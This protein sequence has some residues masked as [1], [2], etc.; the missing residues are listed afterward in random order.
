MPTVLTHAAV[1]L[2]IGLALGPQVVSRRLLIAGVVACMLPDLDVL[3]FRL[4]VAY[5][6]AAGH[7]G[8][9]HSLV[10]SLLL[11]MIAAALAR[12]LRTSRRT[13]FLFVFASAASHG[14]LDMVTNGG[15]GV[16]L[17]WPLS[18]ERFFFPWQVI[19]ASPL[20]LRRVFSARG[21]AVFGSEILWVWLPTMAV[22]SVAVLARRRRRG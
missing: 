6:D 8:I 19:E 16:A 15:M 10:F 9:T 3:A 17:W 22:A 14:L 21:A 11:A 12:G 18:N 4:G 5:S 1:P 20:S 13:A 7:R 2:A